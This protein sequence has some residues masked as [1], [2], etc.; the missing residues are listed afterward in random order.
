MKQILLI[1]L[2]SLLL[3]V[4][5][6]AQDRVVN[7]KVT[8]SEDGSATPGV[9]VLVKGTSMGTTTD[10]D[11]KFSISVPEGSNTLVL[12]FIGYRTTEVEIGTRTIVD[13]QLESDI[14]QLSEVVVVGYGTQIKQDL[15]GN[16]AQVKGDEIRNVP[17][18]SFEQAIQGRAAGVFVE[19]GNGKLGQ[20]IKVRIRGASSVSAGNQPL[21]VIDGIPLTTANQSSSTAAT[22]PLTDI[23]PTDIESIEILKDA[24]A[25]AIYGSRA[26]NGVVLITTR[27]GKSGKT[28]FNVGYQTG[29]SEATGHREWLN[30]QEYVDFFKEARAA[31]DAYTITSI[32]N[33]FTR[34]AAGDRTAWENPGSP[35]YTNTNWEDQVLRK[36][37]INQFDLSASGGNDKTRFFASGQWSDQK[38]ILIGNKLERISGRLNLDHKATEQLSFGLNFTLT[39]TTNYRLSDDNAFSTPMQSVALAPMTPPIDPRTGLLSGV[40]DLATGSPNTNF[41]TYYNPIIDNSYGSRK[42]GVFRSLG[43]ANATYKF[44]P[45]LSFRTEFGYDLLSQHEDRYYG[46]ETTRNTTAPNG[47]AADVWTQV[48]NYTTNTFL[49]FEK[50]LNEMHNIEAVGGM[51]YQDSHSDYTY[52]DGQQFPS[53]AYKE[54]IA[55]AKITAGNTQVN[56]FTFLSYFARANYKFKNRYLLGLSGR[57]DGSSRFGSGSKYGFFPA[58]SAGW[59]MSE[60]SFLSDNKI[61]EFLKIRASYGITGNA[62]IGNF[63][64][65]GLYAGD[66][67]YGG[68]GGQRP[69][70]LPNPD[71]KWEQTA[72]MDIGIDYGI[73]NNRI[74]GEIDYYIKKTSDLL[75]N[76]NLPGSSGYETQT[77]NVGKMENKGVEFVLNSEN[78]V[79]NFKWNTSFNFARNLNKITD[80][81]GQVIQGSFLNRAIEGQS[82]GVFYGPKYAGVDPANGDALYYTKNASGELVTTNDYNAAEY[83]VIG[84]PNPKFIAG[85]TNNFSFKGID[86]SVLFQ[87]VFGNDVYN[88]G[89]KFMSANG[90]FFDNQ[91]KDQ[92]RRWQKPG[93]ITDVPQA[94]L[95]GANGTGESS[96]YLSDA[97]YVR[98]KTLTIGYNLPSSIISKANLTKLRVYFS[99]Q[100]LLTITDYKGWDPE[101]NSD[102]YASNVN[103]GIDFYSAPQPKTLTFGINVGF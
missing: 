10:A 72:Q 54:L 58:A 30:T 64:S 11:G 62:E 41:P 86:V 18:P 38:G 55:S 95:L 23:N 29:T 14:T 85:I 5:G 63:A 66:A 22:N 69:S 52:V 75:L 82:L 44:T 34:Y 101:V 50:T 94:R 46:K 42:T 78:L 4:P 21:Y 76:V 43:S 81:Q 7:G 96:R 88:G 45:A 1:A 2:A 28:N 31:T 33:R 35:T 20:G 70:Q 49:R 9:N 73:F 48:F 47:Y 53:N 87:G 60:E 65:R 3:Y 93:D 71:L 26:A 102:S 19:S 40:L 100:N 36:G 56:D 57:V 25:S 16:I 84:N 6:F 74:T 68:I 39:H 89:G 27:R 92:L 61:V 24:S 98:L 12:S 67:G 83:M 15:T 77:R 79:G 59:I 80:L 103:Q 8:S 90:D 32:E 37:G 51:S 91:T 17:V 99:A 13:V 97:S